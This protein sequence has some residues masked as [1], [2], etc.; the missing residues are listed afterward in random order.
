MKDWWL[1]ADL[2]WGNERA[3]GMLLTRKVKDCTKCRE[4]KHGWIKSLLD[5]S[6]FSVAQYRII[7]IWKPQNLF[8]ISACVN[9]FNLF[10]IVFFI[11]RK[12]ALSVTDRALNLSNCHSVLQKLIE[13]ARWGKLQKIQGLKCD[14]CASGCNKLFSKFI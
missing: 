1:T 5:H 10:E 7:H 11:L 12:K 2:L 9:I 3:G 14:R 4:I 13:K 6:F 8:Y